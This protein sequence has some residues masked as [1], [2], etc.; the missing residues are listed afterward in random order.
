[1]PKGKQNRCSIC[2]RFYAKSSECVR[3]QEN[4]AIRNQEDGIL[5]SMGCDLDWGQYPTEAEIHNG[6]LKLKNMGINLHGI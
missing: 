1:M 4:R 5:E 3:C 6:K 2:G